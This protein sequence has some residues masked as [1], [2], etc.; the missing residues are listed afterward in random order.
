MNIVDWSSPKVHSAP[1]IPVIGGEIAQGWA[2]F[3]NSAG[4][5]NTKMSQQSLNDNGLSTINTTQKVMIDGVEVNVDADFYK[6]W[7]ENNGKNAMSLEWQM[8]DMKSDRDNFLKWSG[9]AGIVNNTQQNWPAVKQ[10]SSECWDSIKSLDSLSNKISFTQDQLKYI[11]LAKEAQSKDEA[12]FY[13]SLSN[14]QGTGFEKSIS[15]EKDTAAMQKFSTYCQDMLVQSGSMIRN[16]IYNNV[17]AQTLQL[18]GFTNKTD[19]INWFDNQIASGQVQLTSQ[20]VQALNDI[21]YVNLNGAKI[22]VSKG[23]IMTYPELA[24]QSFPFPDSLYFTPITAFMSNPAL[25]PFSFSIVIDKVLNKFKIVQ[26]ALGSGDVLKS[27]Y[28]LTNGYWPPIYHTYGLCDAISF[29]FDRGTYNI[30][31]VQ[32]GSYYTQKIYPGIESF[33]SDIFPRD[34]FQGNC[35]VSTSIP[36]VVGQVPVANYGDMSVNPSSKV[37]DG[38][39]MD[40]PITIP[41]PK[42]QVIPGTSTLDIPK[43][44]A[45][46]TAVPDAITGTNA[47]TVPAVIA[48]SFPDMPDLSVP[49]D[50]TGKFPFCIP[51]DFIRGLKVLVVTPEPPNLNTEIGTTVQGHYIGGKLNLDFSMFDKLA[52]LSRWLTTLAF[53][54]SLILLTRKLTKH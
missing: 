38:V 52:R 20:Q 41:I 12:S 30:V 16:A 22:D 39:P 36:S 47:V 2:L 25:T 6:R 10:V 24:L 26:Y 19:F 23:K 31:F 11:N 33:P 50:I 13:M 15:Y 44:I 53:S 17:N 42:P 46:S 14:W 1:L 7:A 37:V 45:Q 40:K 4:I 51:F 49:K 35:I 9:I 18:F 21:M 5:N 48:P 29:K 8:S 32:N 54:Y 34:L 43:A 28:G 3:A 27:W